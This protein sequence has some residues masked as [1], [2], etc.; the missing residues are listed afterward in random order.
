MDA[1]PVRVIVRTPYNRPG[2]PQPDPVPVSSQL[3]QLNGQHAPTVFLQV[4]W[5]SDKENYL[6][7][8]VAES[9]GSESG[10][11][12]CECLLL[13]PRVSLTLVPYQW[14]GKVLAARLDVLLPYLLYH[15]TRGL[16]VIKRLSE[17][18]RP[19]RRTRR[20]TE[21]RGCPRRHG[22]TPQLPS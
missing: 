17:P 5:S 16:Q 14:L 11:P 3:S 6:W 12:G 18:E 8:V 7:Q 1:H 10:A 13:L 15:T 20:P 2:H 4:S 21:R 19:E 9:R 22:D